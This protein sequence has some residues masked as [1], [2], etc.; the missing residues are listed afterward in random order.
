MYL[1]E[2]NKKLDE[3]KLSNTQLEEAINAYEKLREVYDNKN[4]QYTTLKTQFDRMVIE[5]EN[6]KKLVGQQKSNNVFDNSATQA[7]I[8]GNTHSLVRSKNSNEELYQQINDCVKPYLTYNYGKNL[9]DYEKVKQY[10]S[11]K[12]TSMGILAKISM[13]DEDFNEDGF[14][15]IIKITLESVSLLFARHNSAIKHT[16][17]LQYF[18][19]ADREETIATMESYAIEDKNGTI[20][21]G[22]V[23]QLSG[24]VS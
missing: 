8:S 16:K 20:K 17:F 6:L 2:I 22:R 24:N 1:T 9:Q 23:T 15:S 11:N 13:I 7:T 14:W 19:G 10:I 4:N 5:N 18:E 21:K 3:I 12:L